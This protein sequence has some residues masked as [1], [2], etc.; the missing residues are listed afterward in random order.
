MALTEVTTDYEIERIDA[1]NNAVLLKRSNVI[2]KDD[3]VVSS[4]EE[5]ASVDDNAEIKTLIDSILSTAV[6]AL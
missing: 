1:A 6:N 2:K 5:Y 3:V 4:K